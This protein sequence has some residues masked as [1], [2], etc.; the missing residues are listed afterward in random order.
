MR[1]RL[2]EVNYLKLL[3]L[4]G[5]EFHDFM[6][7]ILKKFRQRAFLLLAKDNVQWWPRV[8]QC[9]F[10]LKKSVIF[11]L[12]NPK[13]ILYVKA[14]SA[15]RLLF[16]NRSIWSS[17]ILSVSV[18]CLQTGKLAVKR[19]WTY[20]IVFMRPSDYAD[21]TVDA[22]S[23]ILWK[24]EATWSSNTGLLGEVTM[25]LRKVLLGCGRY[26][27]N[28]R[29]RQSQKLLCFIESIRQSCSHHV[30]SWSVRYILLKRLGQ[31]LI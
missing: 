18:K 30:V 7:R 9:V 28:T 2:N 8:L 5:N 3:L 14:R 24:H 10:S 12:A 27:N 15:I 19:L 23:S 4:T 1:K 26:M 20:S 25:Q 31:L 17:L 16:S 22:Y 21:R 6:T 29:S 13:I 11:N